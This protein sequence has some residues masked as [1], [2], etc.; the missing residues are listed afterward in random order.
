METHLEEAILAAEPR[1]RSHS[2]QKTKDGRIDTSFRQIAVT[3]VIQ[4]SLRHGLSID[5]W[6]PSRQEE[7][8]CDRK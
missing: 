2:R 6:L 4:E 8:D 7:R 5:A 3:R 1:L